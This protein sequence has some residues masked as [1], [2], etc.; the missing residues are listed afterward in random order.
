MENLHKAVRRVI[1]AMSVLSVELDEANT[2]VKRAVRLN[3][4]VQSQG[5]VILER[6]LRAGA[7]TRRVWSLGQASI[8]ILVLSLKSITKQASE[9]DPPSIVECRD[10]IAELSDALTDFAENR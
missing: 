5:L 9:P 6:E 10:A 8:P 3:L 4:E 1:A 7:P 2:P